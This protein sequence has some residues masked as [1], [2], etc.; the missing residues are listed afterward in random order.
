[1][2]T[3]SNK[4]NALLFVFFEYLIF[5]TGKTVTKDKV[6]GLYHSFS[7]LFGEEKQEEVI[8]IGKFQI[9][10]WI[11]KTLSKMSFE[12]KGEFIEFCFS[13]VAT[14][15][16]LRAFELC[17]SNIVGQINDSEFREQIRENRIDFRQL[18]KWALKIII[19]DP[20]FLNVRDK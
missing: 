15:V 9:S 11:K 2:K 6:E 18:P 14:D 3:I 17:R 10:I 1:M 16:D 5:L 7:E 13:K 4:Q 8:K 12:E 20:I 19:K